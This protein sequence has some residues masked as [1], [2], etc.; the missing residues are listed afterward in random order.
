MNK[1]RFA[2][3]GQADRFFAGSRR[4]GAQEIRSNPYA[5][6]RF[7]AGNERIP[8]DEKRT[9]NPRPRRPVR[10]FD[11][12]SLRGDQPRPDSVYRAISTGQLLARKLGRRT[13]IT[14]DDLRQFLAGLLR[15]GGHEQG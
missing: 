8:P 11:Q 13:L 15:A 1:A 5:D 2:D 10:I 6:R 3:A 9:A 14:D 7:A 12:R 4:L